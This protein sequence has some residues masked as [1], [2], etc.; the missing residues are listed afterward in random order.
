M[1]KILERDLFNPELEYMTKLEMRAF[2]NLVKCGEI[3]IFKISRCEKCGRDI[4]NS[5][6]YCSKE[7]CGEIEEECEEDIF[8]EFE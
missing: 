6:K 8:D 5:K 4:I 3:T 2:E 7:C 1:L